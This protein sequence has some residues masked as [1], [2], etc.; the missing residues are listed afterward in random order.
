M[1]VITCKLRLRP[2]IHEIDSCG[3]GAASVADFFL[4]E[5]GGSEGI[6]VLIADVIVGGGIGVVVDFEEEC[7]S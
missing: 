4:A 5:P 2:Q 7:A 1:I 6:D 3:D